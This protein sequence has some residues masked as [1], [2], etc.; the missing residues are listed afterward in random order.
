[1]NYLDDLRDV[2]FNL[3]EWLPLD[4]L[5]RAERYRDF[6]RD[7]LEMTLEEALKMAK[8]EVASTLKDSDR[9]GAR[10][11]DG[12][13]F[14]P[15]SF[16]RGYKTVAEA[17]WIGAAENPEYGGMGMPE[18]VNT[19]VAEFL[20]G[21]NSALALALILCRGTG[22]LVESFG[23]DEM[24]GLFCEKLYSGQW[25]GTMCLTEPGAGSDV[26]ACKT[27]AERLESGRY[28]ISGEKIFITCGEHDLT[29]NI[30]HAVLARIPDAPAGTKGLSLFI[31][32]KL[33]VKGDG[34]LAGG[35]DVAC[36]NI[37]HKIGI[38][39][40]PTCSMVF[41]ANGECEGFL[42]GKEQEGISL[43]FQMMNEA[44]YEVGLQAMAIASAAHQAALAFAK[45][46]LQGKHYKDRRPDAP[47][48]PITEHPDVRRMLLDMQ[49][50]VQGMR[51]LLFYTACNMDTAGVTEGEEKEKLHGMVEL[52]TPV[53][54]AWCSDW[55][56]R[57]TEWAVQTYGGYGYTMEYPAELYLRDQKITSIYE[58]TNGIQ[59]LDLVGRKF[60]MQ[61]GAYLKAAIDAAAATAKEFVTDTDLGASAMLLG[62]AAKEFASATESY[63]KRV[64]GMEVAMTNAVPILDMLGHLFC[65]HLLIRQA[66]LAKEKLEEILSDKMVSPKNK[67]AYRALLEESG[68]ARFYH[69]KI[70]TAKHFAHRGLPLVQALA[71]GVRAGEVAPMEAVF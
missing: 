22:H 6:G 33:R 59:A 47:Q 28:R 53:C 3:F 66:A 26:G 19:G 71:T 65:G 38:H 5:L 46:R 23:T 56:F 2:K 42:L 8:G 21:A 49:A 14:M 54:K 36:G 51:A 55:G 20:M 27:K 37:E 34:S 61:G 29:P 25:S 69:N 16:R 4:K 32:P 40:S 35:N 52:L 57:V 43:M 58:G 11:E 17:G 12:K 24:K 45:E 7:D 15:E 10:F 70:Q 18:C 31:V 13:V 63:T 41:G 62:S 68:E 64:D 9:I 30:V 50:Y 44:R 39:G 48:V 60:R 67:A 1:M